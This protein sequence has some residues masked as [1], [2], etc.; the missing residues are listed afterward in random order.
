MNWAGI[1]KLPLIFVIENNQ[2]AIS[3]PSEEEIAGKLADRAQGYGFPGYA[4]DG[5]APFEVVEAMQRAVARARSGA[6]PTL[7]EA[8]T[9]RHGGHHVNDPGLYMDP[10][11]LAEWK[12]RD[13]LYMLRGKLAES[14]TEKIENQVD[15]EIAVA[16]EFAKNSPEPSVEEFLASIK[17]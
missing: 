10:D 1:H 15:E 14:K 7:I 4:I 13:P 9:Y 16:I 5:N 12:V 2:Y 3:V 8:N 17:G 11:V 6:G